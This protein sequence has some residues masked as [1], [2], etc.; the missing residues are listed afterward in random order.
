[1]HVWYRELLHKTIPALIEKWQTV[2]GVSVHA[3]FLQRM[4]TKW[5]ACNHRTDTIR[6][7]PSWSRN[8]KTCGVCLSA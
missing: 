7:I 3:Y 6:L 4:K 5:G 1:M 2:L 8:L